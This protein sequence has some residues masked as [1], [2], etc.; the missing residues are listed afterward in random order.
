MDELIQEYIKGHEALSLDLYTDTLGY[1]TIGWGHLCVKR[2]FTRITE[3]QAQGLFD[4][5]YCNAKF[6]ISHLLPG[7]SE[8]SDGRKMALLDMSFQMN[9][10][11]LHFPKALDHLKTGEWASAAA[12]FLD[13]I[14]A[15]KQTPSRAIDNIILLING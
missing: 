4:V 7:F 3:A 9:N 12:D 6:F 5:D 15:R 8:F 14:W 10:R 2:E 1:P 11:L 13:S